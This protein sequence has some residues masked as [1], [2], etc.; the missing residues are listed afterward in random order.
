MTH[1]VESVS[2]LAHGSEWVDHED[3]IIG[4][5]AGLKALRDAC[6]IAL[7]EGT[8]FR[9]DLGEFVG[10]KRLESSWFNNPQDSRPTRFMNRV[11]ALFLVLVAALVLIGAFTVVK[12]FF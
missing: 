10:V 5:E 11:F 2:H 4:N 12:W 6:D 3:C 9:N 7:R 8:C 1:N